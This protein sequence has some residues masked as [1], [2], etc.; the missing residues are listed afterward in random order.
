MW[1]RWFEALERLG[2]IRL[3]FTSGSKLDVGDPTASDAQ[4]GADWRRYITAEALYDVWG[5]VPAGPWAPFH[6]VP[7]F[8]ALDR[9]APRSIGPARPPGQERPGNGGGNGN[10]RIALPAHTRPD[11][12]PP[13][14]LTPQTWTILDLPGPAAVEAA[15]WLIASGGCQPVCTFDNWPHPKGLL[16]PERILAELIRWASTVAAARRGLAPGSPPLWICDSE[17]LGGLSGKPG[18]FDNRYYLDDSVLPGPALLKGAGI[19]KVVYLTLEKNAAVVQDLEAYFADLLAAG[20][21]VLHA[22]LADPWL[23][24]TRFSAPPTPRPL[25]TAGF[26]RSAA[27]GFG[28]VV[29]EPSSG[30]SS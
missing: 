22:A 25:P 24:A 20:I 12:P 1:Q 19:G 11:A 3:H 30:G 16:K 8:A 14:W 13:S 5:P 2:R 26:H 29:P 15:V 9:M 6:C 10:G 27:G 18:E 4:G 23:E 17:R 7:L 28:T 21:T